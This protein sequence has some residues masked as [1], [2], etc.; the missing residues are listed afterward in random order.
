MSQEK[1]GRKGVSAR[2]SESQERETIEYTGELNFEELSEFVKEHGFDNLLNMS[3]GE[4]R[5]LLLG[6]KGIGPE[7]AD[8]I[9]LYA[10]EKPTFVI[11]AYTK[12]I[13]SRLGLCD[14]DVDYHVLQKRFMDEL[15][16]DVSL[17]N[18]YHALIVEHAK[19]HCKTKPECKN[20]PLKVQWRRRLVC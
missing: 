20:C 17:F 14:S 5:E 12:R 3:A 4:L 19:R 13:F 8:S 1:R 16:K 15:E 18:E 11:D 2:E 7:T 9:V 10:F 6:V